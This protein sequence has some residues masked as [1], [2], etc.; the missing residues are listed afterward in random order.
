[1][2]TVEP[3]EQIRYRGEKAHTGNMIF[4]GEN[5]PAGAIFD[6]WSGANDTPVTFD[7]FDGSGA[8]VASLEAVASRGVNR[9]VWDLRH[10]WVDGTEGGGRGPLVV[11]GTYTARM[12]Q[13]G[14][15]SQRSVEVRED[16]RLE[17]DPSVRAQWTETLLEL[18]RLAADAEALAETVDGVLERLDAVDAPLQVARALELQIRDMA[19]ETA[20]LDSRTGGLYGSATGWVG[21]LSADQASQEEFLSGMLRTLEAEWSAVEVRLPR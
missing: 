3:A 21:P 16:P 10:T 20:E 12:T 11:P 4:E 6:Y 9:T 7:L 18:W 19:R 1:F 5:P 15:T 2:F 17:H 14:V 13:G 8:Q